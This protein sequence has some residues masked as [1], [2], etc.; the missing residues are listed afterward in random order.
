MK[1]ARIA[2]QNFGPYES[3]EVIF[4]QPFAAFRA[5]NA[6]GKTKAAQA[7]QLPLTGQS[8]GTDARGAGAQD[9]IRLGAD[10]AILTMDLE[11]AKGPMRL[12][13]QYGPGKNP[14]QKIIAGSGGPETE[15]LSA[16]FAK[17]LEANRD[18]LSC[19][20]DSEFF[21]GEKPADQ[22]AILA[23]L[24]LPTKYDWDADPEAAAMMALAT[25]HFPKTD[26][27]RPPV[28]IIDE[29][30]G[31]DKTGAYSARKTAKAT[32]AGIHIP[33]PPLKP[34]HD[35]NE[36][37]AKLNV[38]R[39]NQTKEAK[40]VKQGGTVQVGRVEQSLTQERET[41]AK[42]H[43]DRTDALA[44]QAA[45]DQEI[46]DGPAMTA[47]K[48]MAAKRKE[49]GELGQQIEALNGEIADQQQ[50]QDIFNEMLVDEHGN[51]VDE[52]PCLTCTQMVTRAF[53]T[54]RVADH[55]K[56]QAQAEA[57]KA[58]VERRQKELGDIAGAEAAI[59][60]QEE[61]TAE[62]LACVKVVTACAERIT[63]IEAA[64]KDL[65]ASLATAKAAEANPIDT[66]T[67]DA[68]T[69]ELG[70]W[71]VRLAP[72]VTYA[73]TLTQIAEARKRYDEQQAIVAEL[74]TLCAFFGPKGIKSRLIAANIGA[75]EATVNSVIGEW[76]D[77]FK[78]KL[79]FEPWSFMVTYD[80]IA[81]H[82]LPLK[83]LSGFERLAF[84]ASFQCGVAI[85][86]KIK[87]VM[88]DKL[89][90]MAKAP[91]RQFVLLGAL[92]RLLQSKQLDQAICLSTDLSTDVKPKDGVAYY[93]IVKADK[94]ST[95][96]RL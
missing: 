52:A 4:D 55:K 23:A 44:K 1:I 65:E 41:L 80:D 69:K 59:K 57:E 87:M 49:Y 28:V 70:E 14:P 48:Q 77:H 10:K 27:T 95:I 90:T 64:I 30:Y 82:W 43:T 67:L 96:E 26:W 50:A 81:P 32:L 5:D 46:L 54:A 85:A 6:S 71:E 16:G 51:P 38:L 91:H 34:E 20:L 53:I 60:R 63:F 11:T 33:T 79:E 2:L 25:K 21:I 56:L 93:R 9:K 36:V 39:T 13:T 31:D 29:I 40:K 12:V 74:E 92:N 78:I 75:F 68:L 72:A 86:S 88:I 58:K 19:C 18:R 35:A 8:Y 42:A 83:E 3:A 73:S 66:S 47:H 62:K 22:K 61:K 94:R 89:D 76:P 17:F 24:V 15:N 7:M 37:Q 45:I 84:C